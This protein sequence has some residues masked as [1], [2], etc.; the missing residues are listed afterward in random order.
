MIRLGARRGGTTT[1]PNC[2]F[3]VGADGELFVSNPI[4]SPKLW[5]IREEEGIQQ[6][7]DA[8]TINLR[9]DNLPPADFD[10]LT[11]Q[12]TVRVPGRNRAN[13]FVPQAD[14]TWTALATAHP[15]IYTLQ[16]S[17]YG[18][19]MDY[20]GGVVYVPGTLINAS[21]EFLNLASFLRAHG[22]GRVTFPPR[23]GIYLQSGP[24]YLVENTTFDCN[25]CFLFRADAIDQIGGTFNHSVE[26]LRYTGNLNANTTRVR[27]EDLWIYDNRGYQLYLVGAHGF[28]GGSSFEP[29]A[30]IERME[31][32]R[33]HSRASAGYGGSTNNNNAIRH[34]IKHGGSVKFCD[35]DSWDRKNT[36]NANYDITFRDEDHDWVALGDQGTNLSFI[37]GE[38]NPFRTITV[39]TAN[40][41]VTWRGHTFHAGDR[42]IID[43]TVP[44][45]GIT[46]PTTPITISSITSATQFVIPASGSATDVKS[47]GGNNV[48]IRQCIPNNGLL[49]V[50]GETYLKAAR[51]LDVHIQMGEIVTLDGGSIFNGIN[52]I[53]SFPC[54][55]IDDDYFYLEAATFDLTI[56][57]PFTPDSIGSTVIVCNVPGYDQAAGRAR[58]YGQTTGSGCNVLSTYAGGSYALSVIDDDHFSIDLAEHDGP[59]ATDTASFGGDQCHVFLGVG[60]TD[61]GP[62]GGDTITF[63]CPHISGGDRINDSRGLAITVQNLRVKMEEY[64]RNGLYQ[65]G[66][67]PLGTAGEGATRMHVDGYTFTG[68]N[69][70]WI[71]DLGGSGN[72]LSLSGKYAKMS[73]ISIVAPSANKGINISATAVGAQISDYTV[74]GTQV[75]VDLVGNQTQLKSGRL[76]NPKEVGVRVWGYL[77]TVT[78]DDNAPDIFTP[79]NGSSIVTVTIPGYP[80]TGGRAGFAG[81]VNGSGC[82][83]IPSN[84]AR[85]LI[86]PVDATTFTIDL[87]EFV[88]GPGSVATSSDPFGGDHT[89]VFFGSLPNTAEGNTIDGIEMEQTEV[90][91]TAIA[92]AIGGGGSDI[93]LGQEGRADDTIIRNS[94]QVGFARPYMDKGTNTQWAG[95]NVGLRNDVVSDTNV[96]AVSSGLHLIDTI[97]LAGN[98]ASIDRGGLAVYD[99]I[100][101]QVFSASHNS[102]SN[103]NFG[104][105]LIT[106]GATVYSSADDYSWDGTNLT[107]ANLLF[108][109]GV[110]AGTLVHG[111]VRIRN[112][113]KLLTKSI[114]VRGGT[115]NSNAQLVAS[116]AR[117]EH[118]VALT[119]I[120]LLIGG[121]TW[122]AGTAYLWGR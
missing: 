108:C 29:A 18:S 102:L 1:T 92:V 90:G 39:G 71:R 47:F 73:H 91:N 37:R 117:L 80:Q 75:G 98:A 2:I 13:N 25:G 120:R 27:V 16:D 42:V 38:A 63:V 30:W 59:E 60:A 31:L 17:V 78:F 106:E 21:P 94:K 9:F 83:I 93:T 49:T 104:V 76:I 23:G 5:T 6:T 111:F 109:S 22:G 14:G 82:T 50:A 122:S 66:G 97:T 4:I 110:A 43:S 34:F 105:Q 48:R 101:L 89:D 3:A 41:R 107:T 44:G 51:T 57:N 113:N 99:E 119:G 86:T 118:A 77:D 19:G 64:G 32:F 65:R 52:P 81:A 100:Y 10:P 53:G 58:F 20:A 96:V 87:T 79:T 114:S 68:Q 121:G 69:P 28:E 33:V 116:N 55:T 45:F 54:I 103:Q 7:A 88:T 84:F 36:L 56:L 61:T 72:A 40:V 24:M 115:R 112:F 67:E 26:P 62:G 46:I 12:I 15:Y 8:D 70:V 35:G 85:Y 74:E 11:E 95:G